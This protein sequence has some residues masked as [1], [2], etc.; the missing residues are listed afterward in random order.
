MTSS[1]VTKAGT[2]SCGGY[3]S[4]TC[5]FR[6][7]RQSRC[8]K[9]GMERTGA[10]RRGRSEGTAQEPRGAVPRPWH[11]KGR[12]PC[13]REQTIHDSCAHCRACGVSLSVPTCIA[14]AREAEFALDHTSAS[15]VLDAMLVV[16]CM[17]MRTAYAAFTSVI[18]QC[19]EAKTSCRSYSARTSYTPH[20]ALASAVSSGAWPAKWLNANAVG[21]SAD[22]GCSASFTALCCARHQRLHRAAAVRGR[23]TAVQ[24]VDGTHSTIAHGAALNATGTATSVSP[25]S[26]QGLP[27]LRC[28]RAACSTVTVRGT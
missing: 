1:S 23:T 6:R 24:L 21:F 13:G 12:R 17:R 26:A 4:H 20:C 3:D 14:H 9:P 10:H 7:S 2:T 28:R 15:A 18:R 25:L 8:R 16:F 11:P 19:C 22:G 5:A 27:G